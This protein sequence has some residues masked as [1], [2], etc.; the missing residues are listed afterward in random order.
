MNITESELAAS[1]G[2]PSKLLAGLRKTIPLSMP[3]HFSRTPEI[4]YTEA[5][6]D[7][8]LEKIGADSSE[9]AEPLIAELRIVRKVTNQSIVLA[10]KKEAGGVLLTLKVPTYGVNGA[11]LNHFRPGQVCR[12]RH[13]EGAIWTYYGPRPKHPRDA[14]AFISF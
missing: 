10:E 5:G 1:L 13:I 9:L 12:A 7:A 14:S 4:I 8:I 11:T 2:V 3:L 6:R